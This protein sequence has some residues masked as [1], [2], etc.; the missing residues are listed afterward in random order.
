[1]FATKTNRLIDPRKS[2]H[3]F[4]KLGRAADYL[5]ARCVKNRCRSSG[6]NKTPSESERRMTVLTLLIESCKL[7]KRSTVGRFWRDFRVWKKIAKESL[8]IPEGRTSPMSVQNSKGGKE[9]RD[10]TVLSFGE[11]D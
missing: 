11:A 1:M 7:Q 10:K 6:E 3:Y 9:N 8:N 4:E 5:V 2:K